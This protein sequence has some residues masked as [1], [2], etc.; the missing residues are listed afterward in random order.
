MANSSIGSTQKSKQPAAV[1]MAV[2]Q[3]KEACRISEAN[4]TLW[5]ERVE[6]MTKSSSYGWNLGAGYGL[7][8]SGLRRLRTLVEEP[9]LT[10]WLAGSLNSGRSRWRALHEHSQSLNSEMLYIFPNAEAHQILLV[11]AKK[12]DSKAEGLFKIL[13]NY[14][15]VKSTRD[16]DEKERQQNRSEEMAGNEPAWPVEAGLEAAYDP[17]RALESMLEYLTRR[18]ACDAAYLAIRSG[19]S[20]QIQAA[21]KCKNGVEGREI[22]IRDNPAIE[23]LRDQGKGVVAVLF[24]PFEPGASSE[25][26][27]EV[28]D[29]LHQVM[30]QAAGSWMGIPVKIGRRVIGL[31]G[32]VTAPGRGFS[33]T[34]MDEASR[35]VS[36]LAF[37]IESAIIFREATRYLEQLALLNELAASAGMSSLGARSRRDTDI[38]D[39]GTSDTGTSS[40]DEFARRVMQRLR[41]A[42]DSDWAAVLLI[43]AD[44]ERLEEAGGGSQS[45]PAWVVPVK[46]SLM[47]QVMESGLPIRVGD[48]RQAKR[49]IAIQAKVRSELAVPLKYRGKVRGVL[50][51]VSEASNAFSLQ[52]EQL[53]V[54]VAS[55]LA[56]LFENVR[57]NEEMRERARKLADSVRQ[58]EAV[59]DT[60]LDLAADLDM[61]RLLRRV[62]QRARDLVGARGAELGLFNESEQVVEIVVFEMM[63]EGDDDERGGADKGEADSGGTSNP[64][65]ERGSEMGDE[66]GSIDKQP[67]MAGVAGKIAALGEAMVV[68]RYED[69]AGR[70]PSR[71]YEGVH[72][73]AGVPLK[74]KGEVIGTLCVLDDRV[75]KSFTRDDVRLLEYL[76]PQA[77]ISI[78]NARLYQELGRRM[79]AQRVAEARLV[80]SARLAAVG[81]M[82]AGMA[83]ELNNPLT[84]VSGF[85][86]LAL[87]ELE[88][89]PANLPALISDLE[90]VYQE[91]QRAQGVV[92][93]LLDFARPAEEER[94]PGDINIIIEQVLP[95]FQHLMRSGGVHLTTDLTPGLPWI[96]MDANQIKQVLIN[97]MHNALQAMP[98]GGTLRIETGIEEGR[99]VDGRGGKAYTQVRP[100]DEPRT[101]D[102]RR[103]GGEGRHAGEGGHEQQERRVRIE[104]SDNGEGMTPEVV[105]RI[106]EP[107]FSTRPAGKGSGLGLSVSYG[108]IA[109]HGGWIEVESIPGK[110]SCF[111]I[112]LPAGDVDQEESQ[113]G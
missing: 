40:A 61:E 60:S 92:R 106:F 56:G 72:A 46:G 81:E 111:R 93:R 107:F 110:G 83:H 31:I 30:A 95:I 9:N 108:I 65:A 23:R 64:M 55:Q 67:L 86:E 57:L 13:A 63:A 79:E 2:A 36:A 99:N 100:Y 39:D 52:D 105:A 16:A 62:A 3:L 97:L 82:A 22:S 45:G 87:S 20:F 59:R 7:N 15:V 24:E 43:S 48:V 6:R 18:V 89:G 84:T 54:V 32:F 14:P 44:G 102:E 66:G 104:V 1:Q 76:A 69:W 113:D 47:G 35:Y 42:F 21:W 96:T 17:Q 4:W 109:S 58:L 26:A 34:M 11:G 85:V 27:E 91:A 78:R 103:T 74:F 90:L 50:V 37:Y 70:W 98:R 12:L 101:D 8:R 80:Q 51:L 5:I 33:T 77:A 71:R 10:A 94:K 112:F 73:V 28:T 49:Y 19:E 38:T 68:N 41:R 53:L 25:L 88:E 29:S 75:E